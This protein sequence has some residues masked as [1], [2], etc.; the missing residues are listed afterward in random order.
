MGKN[1]K[2]RSGAVIYAGTEIGDFL[3]TGHNVVIREENTIGNHLSI[4]SNS[5]I[6]YGCRIGNNVKIHSNC[7]IAQFTTIEDDVFLAPGVI[8]ANDRYP[9]SKSL[10]GPTIK[11]G[12]KIG[13]N[14]TLLPGVTIGE[15]ALIGAGAVVTRD[16]PAGSV[17]WGNP[18]EVKK[19]ISQIIDSDGKNPYEKILPE[20]KKS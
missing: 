13:V 7:Y 12:A 6:D 3:E 11:K 4:W 1:A 9:L 18:A 10:K 14:V 2:I 8:I 19:D 17:A 5:I 20:L 15:Y 16:I